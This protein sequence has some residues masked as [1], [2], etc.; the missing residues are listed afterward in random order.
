MS[1]AVPL[2]SRT[3][4]RPLFLLSLLIAGLFLVPPLPAYAL[5]K[6][7]YGDIVVPPRGV[8]ES[9]STVY[10]D[11]V[12][13]GPCQGNVKT[14]FGNVEVYAPVEG[15][16]ETDFG[17][18]YVNA[19]VRGDVI[20]G[21]GDVR[22]GPAGRIDG[23]VRIDSGRLYRHPTSQIN[24]ELM[25]GMSSWPGDAGDSRVLGLVGWFFGTLVFVAVAVLAAVFVPRQLSS[26]A[27]KI[28]ES[29][30]RSLLV[31]LASVPAAVV[32]S[33]VLA[34]SLV[35]IPLLLLAAPAYLAFVFFG[36]LAAAY[37]LGRR[38]LL[39]TGRYRAGNALAAAVGALILSATYLI[40]FVGSL[41]LYGFA[42]LGTGAAIMALFSRSR[43]PAYS[44]YEARVERPRV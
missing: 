13:N 35:G 25:T 31:G 4:V 2:L 26:S 38:V 14:G 1:V 40:P 7:F 32:L 3:P 44:P 9:I 23:R 27:R 15:Q 5:E 29:F 19:P 12:V 42:L 24:G 18:V 21:R 30:G 43:R 33:V 8:S 16:V 20:V 22:L 34:A 10:G 37:F 41:L 6:Q 11:I 36:A 39:A 17:D 28:E